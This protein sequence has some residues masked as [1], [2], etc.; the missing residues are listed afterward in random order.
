MTASVD[1]PPVS[2]AIGQPGAIATFTFAGSAG[3]AVYVTIPSSSLPDEYRRPGGVAEFEASC[4]TEALDGHVREWTRELVDQAHAA[5]VKVYGRHAASNAKGA[6]VLVVSSAVAETNPEVRA[7]RGRGI[8]VV[9]RAQM[10]AELGRMK[11]TVTV[12]GSHG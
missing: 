12:A 8:P 7:A 11:K 3:Q 2:A 9:L 10:L 5:G 4:P 6:Q 1:G